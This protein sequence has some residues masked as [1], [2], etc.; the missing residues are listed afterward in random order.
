[1]LD[2][3][4]LDL[5]FGSTLWSFNYFAEVAELADAHGS[6]PC[7]RKGVRVQLPSSAQM[8]IN[9]PGRLAHQSAGTIGKH[10]NNLQQS[11]RPIGNRRL[12]NIPIISNNRPGRLITDDL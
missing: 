7:A 9:R 8:N 12:V 11:S 5:R 1:M 2:I 10:L 3:Y 6:E 4:T